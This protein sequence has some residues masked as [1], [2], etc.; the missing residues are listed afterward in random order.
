MILI[1]IDICC[2]NMG[3][4]KIA[5]HAGNSSNVPPSNMF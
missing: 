2:G 4:Q 5:Y 1:T 3:K